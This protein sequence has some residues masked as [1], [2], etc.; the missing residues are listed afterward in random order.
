MLNI[1]SQWEQ[2]GMTVRLSLNSTLK[3]FK[4]AVNDMEAKHLYFF[5][6]GAS[7]VPQLIFSDGSFAD[8]RTINNDLFSQSFSASNTSLKGLL[9]SCSQGK[10]E[11]TWQSVF[12]NFEA[13]YSTK[14][15]DTKLI[16][17]LSDQT[18]KDIQ[19]YAD[20]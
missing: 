18:L 14:V 20:K 7:K 1:K 10:F 4:I 3:D 16:N 12:T 13:P 8:A 17:V 2:A 19:T 11:S 5:G 15:L 9:L 6:H